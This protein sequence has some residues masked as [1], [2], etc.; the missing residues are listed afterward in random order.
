MLVRFDKS[1]VTSVVKEFRTFCA[2]FNRDTY[3]QSELSH[4][5]ISDS[6]VIHILNT[7]LYSTYLFAT[8]NATAF[9]EFPMN[10]QTK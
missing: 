5:N 8:Y 4:A 7:H 9:N 6:N 10:L 1:L 2:K 3:F